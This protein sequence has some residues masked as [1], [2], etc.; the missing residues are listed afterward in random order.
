ME[1]T[2]ATVTPTSAWCRAMQ[3]AIREHVKPTKRTD[4]TFRVPS[5]S[6]PGQ[7]HIVTMDASGHII[8]CDCV[9][10]QHGGRIR[11]CKHVAAVALAI[12]F[13]A[14]AHIVPSTSEP[15]SV[16]SFSPSRSQIFRTAR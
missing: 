11:P 12:M 14:G 4:G 1:M 7:D 2:T 16:P 13:L 8:H 15:A 9:G 5:V 6:T 10:W 3:R